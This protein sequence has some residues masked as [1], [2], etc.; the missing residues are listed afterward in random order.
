MIVVLAMGM[1]CARPGFLHRGPREEIA[2]LPPEAIQERDNAA[3]P[4]AETDPLQAGD[5][6]HLQIFRE[7]EISGKFRIMPEGVIRHPLLGDVEL[8]G[9]T[10]RQAEEHIVNLLT[11]DYL[12]NPRVILTVSQRRQWEQDEKLHVL[13]MG[14]VKRPGEV[15]FVPDERLTLLDAIARAGGFTKGASRNRVRVVRV[16]DGERRT[17]RVRV[18][19]I[20]T[21]KRDHENI[22]LQPD[23]VINVPEVWF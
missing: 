21:G 16:I 4:A 22:D 1:G 2:V 6:I 17:L 12:V 5:E 10:A 15:S 20:L 9:Q 18:D 14:E 8:E 3:S 13:V 11:A 7:P 19:D 23:D